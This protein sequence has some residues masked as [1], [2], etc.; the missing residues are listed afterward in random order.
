MF[1]YPDIFPQAR[2]WLR[3]TGSGISLTLAVDGAEISSPIRTSKKPWFLVFVTSPGT[4]YTLGQPSF[5][6]LSVLFRITMFPLWKLHFWDFPGGPVVN[7]PCSHCRGHGFDIRL[8][9]SDPSC[10]MVKP[11]NHISIP[12]ISFYLYCNRELPC[13]PP[14]FPAGNTHSPCIYVT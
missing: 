13:C 8:G 4:S 1:P 6:R 10:H 12:R 14:L 11:R 7:T 5:G 9:N 2:C 3:V